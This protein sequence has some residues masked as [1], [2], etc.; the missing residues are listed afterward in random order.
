M[1]VHAL[2]YP[3]K[4]Y[5]Q[6][7]VIAKGAPPANNGKVIAIGMTSQIAIMRTLF[8][9]IEYLLSSGKYCCVW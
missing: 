6:H 2:T 7:H 1:Y 3:S 8:S 4:I 5:M 9:L